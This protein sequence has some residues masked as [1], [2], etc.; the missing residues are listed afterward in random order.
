MISTL[1]KFPWYM[2]QHI[3]TKQRYSVWNATCQLVKILVLAV[4]QKRDEINLTPQLLKRLVNAAMRCPGFTVLQKDSIAFLV[5]M[6]EMEM[7]GYGL[8]RFASTW[9]HQYAVAVKPGV[10]LDVIEVKSPAP[11]YSI[12]EAG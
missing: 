12:R 11:A 6:N 2:T 8:P 5:T 4:E 1:K 7:R 10:P 3:T 9:T